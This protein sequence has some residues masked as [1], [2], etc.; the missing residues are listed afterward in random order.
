MIW[1]EYQRCPIYVEC[2]IRTM[3]G[4]NV[5]IEVTKFV[6]TEVDDCAVLSFNYDIELRPS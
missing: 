6:D 2:K 5:L 4:K 3:N 1:A